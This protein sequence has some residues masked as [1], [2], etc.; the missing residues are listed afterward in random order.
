MTDKS[1]SNNIIAT[2]CYVVKDGKVLMLHRM[3]KENDM[4]FGKYNGLGGK[5]EKGE[6]PYECV[7]REV[8]EESGIKIKNPF[9]S[10]VINF[11]E[12]DGKNNW[13]VFVFLA[14]EFEGSLIDSKEGVLEWVDID[15]INNLNLW[16]GDYIFLRYVFKKK[17]F[18]AT[19]YYLKNKLVDYKI[20]IP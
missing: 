11:P 9:L 13:I 18:Y 20:Q 7:I 1:Y 4:H 10:G 6:T 17:F 19:F 15:K 5:L 16:E 2:L 8:R 14:E 12:F 3:K